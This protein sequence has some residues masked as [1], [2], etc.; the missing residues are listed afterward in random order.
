M[1]ININKCLQI[2]ACYITMKLKFNKIN[3]Q[4]DFKIIN[5]KI[6]NQNKKYL[7]SDHHNQWK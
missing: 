3:E 5:N 4:I 2:I 1:K 7:H 6:R